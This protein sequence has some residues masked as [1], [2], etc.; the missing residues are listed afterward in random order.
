MNNWI[1][2]K[3]KLPECNIIVKVR[4]TNGTEALDFVN[5]PIDNDMPFQHNL[6][7]EWRNPTRDEL[8]DFMSKANRQMK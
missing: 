2:I 4:L 6:V 7:S 8:N 5:E 3:E 1:S